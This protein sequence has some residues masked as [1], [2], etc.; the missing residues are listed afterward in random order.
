[1]GTWPSL[2]TLGKTDK[3]AVLK[4]RLNSRLLLPSPY[5]EPRFHCCCRQLE[6]IF[7]ILSGPLQTQ[8]PFQFGSTVPEPEASWCRKHPDK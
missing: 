1:M 5:K 6:V 2:E 4:K 3:T 7:H 8:I